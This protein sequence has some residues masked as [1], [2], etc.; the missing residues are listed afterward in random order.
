MI[1]QDS[2][3]EGCPEDDDMPGTFW[4]SSHPI[5]KLKGCFDILDD[6]SERE[7]DESSEA[8]N[9]QQAVRLRKAVRRDD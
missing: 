4:T 1:G 6:R 3:D 9:D 7:S 5:R 2:E 8:P